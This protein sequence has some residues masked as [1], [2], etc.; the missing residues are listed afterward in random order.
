MINHGSHSVLGIHVDAVDYE[1]A[2]DKIIGAAKAG[3]ACS[4]SALAVHGVMTGVQDD[5]HAYRL[6]H[7]D[8]VVPDGQPVRWALKW[9][10]GIRLPDRVYGPNLT[11]KVCEAAAENQL[12]VYLYGSEEN[13]LSGFKENLIKKYPNLI[14][15][16]SEP[17]KFRC[18]LEE[19]V[20]EMNIRI[21]Q[22]GA[23]IVFVGLGCPRQEVWAFENREALAMPILAVGAAFDFHAG[24][25][26]QAPEWMQNAGLEWLFR[27]SKEPSRLWKRYVLLNPWYLSML[28]LQKLGFL[29]PE[30]GFS[31]EPAQKKR[32]G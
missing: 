27:L 21:R 11:L 15:C 6:N 2:V 26:K 19:E 4:T 17:S 14:I 20:S 22:S 30:K 31:C 23:K 24:T 5:E 12:P 1:F 32:Y 3:E 8:L 18:L 16:G 7:L 29:R 28:F 9:I 13:V 25:L 10:H